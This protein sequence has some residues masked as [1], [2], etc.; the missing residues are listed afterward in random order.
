[1][2]CVPSQNGLFALCP[3]R[4]SAYCDCDGNVLPCCHCT[5][6]PCALVPITS[7][8]NGSPPDTWYG[9]FSVICTI[10]GAAVFS[11]IAR[12]SGGRGAREPYAGCVAPA[13]IVFRQCGLSQ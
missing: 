6:S 8:A 7:V 1:M 3:Q 9:P 4:H 5:D 2:A 12:T 11:F 10:A 13:R